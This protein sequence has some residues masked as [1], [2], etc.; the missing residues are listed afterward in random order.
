MKECNPRNLSLCFQA[1]MTNIQTDPVMFC[2][3]AHCVGWS[4]VYDERFEPYQFC[5]FVE[6][7]VHTGW[8]CL[9]TLE[10]TGLSQNPAKLELVF[11]PDETHCLKKIRG[12]VGKSN[13]PAPALNPLFVRFSVFSLQ[14]QRTLRAKYL[15]PMRTPN[16]CQSWFRLWSARNFYSS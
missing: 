9:H 10:N 2:K 12:P 16:R 4:V 13:L 15:D 14:V 8:S 3:Q 5:L 1:R 6:A 7:L 11:S